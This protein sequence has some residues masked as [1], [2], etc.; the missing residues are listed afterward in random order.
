MNTD[1]KNQCSSVFIRVPFIGLRRS[2]AERLPQEKERHVLYIKQ[3]DGESAFTELAADWDNLARR[4]LTNTPFQWLAYQRAWW[5]HLQPSGGSLHTLA[6]YEESQLVA[7]ASFYL[8]D[9]LLYFNGC[10][11]ETDYLDLIVPAEHAEAAWTA[12]FDHLCRDDFPRWRGLD[13]CN[14]PAASPSRELLPR[15]AEQHGFSFTESIHEVCP[16]IQLPDSFDTYLDGLESKQRREIKRKLRRADGI[17]VNIHTVGPDEDLAGAVD[18][19]LRLLEKSTAEKADWLNE[20]RRAVFH[21]T[22]QAARAAGRLQLM[23][24][25]VNGQKGAGLF[26]FDYNGR[27]WVYNS[28]LDPSAFSK[29]SLGWV[30]T[31]KAIQSAIEN[32]RKEFDFLRGNEPYKYQF[33]AEDTTIYRLQVLAR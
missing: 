33:G 31:S 21:E 16:I 23:F 14:V 24:A 30:L 15:L 19:F 13:L 17:G 26:N 32:G 1:S 12:V 5:H 18:D 10:V 25:E 2:F 11:E 27:I 28:G 8:L 29:L 20:G 4:S 3:F 7:I 22:A 6:L 9:G